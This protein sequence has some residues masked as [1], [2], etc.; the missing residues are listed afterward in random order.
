MDPG[1]ALSFVHEWLDADMTWTPSA[2]WGLAGAFLG[3]IEKYQL[4][5]NHRSDLGHP[6]AA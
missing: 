1:A 4:R 3:L 5:G 2:G 6:V